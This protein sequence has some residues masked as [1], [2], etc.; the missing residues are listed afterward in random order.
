MKIFHL[1]LFQKKT[2]KSF[3]K[4]KYKI[5]D[6]VSEKNLKEVFETSFL[7]YQKQIPEFFNNYLKYKRFI[8]C[9]SATTVN[10]SY[11]DLRT[12]FR[13]INIMFHSNENI[14]NI[15]VEDFKHISISD[16]TI[17]DINNVKSSIIIEFIFF[18]SNVLNNCSK[19]INR[20]N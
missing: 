10:Q 14:K 5:K 2:L 7:V 18:A 12:F 17:T 19:T 11:F 8:S 20:N 15:F 1:S 3:Q 16:A 9:C 13:Y 6:F 4:M